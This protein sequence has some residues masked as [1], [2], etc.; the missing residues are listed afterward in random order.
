MN[1]VKEVERIL[2][3]S[4]KEGDLGERTIPGA[5]SKAN[6]EL[7]AAIGG[8]GALPKEARGELRKGISQETAWSLLAFAET[9]ATYALRLSDQALFTNGLLA[10]SMIFGVIDARELMLVMSLYH[11]VHR[12][13]GLS[14]SSIL[15]QNDEFAIFVRDFFARD[16]EGK[17]L[18]SMGYTLARDA[19]NNLTYQRTW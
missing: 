12:R 14:V 1:I 11:D 4:K 3:A 10:L 15:D 19:S 16:E 7:S 8:F 2:E 6:A 5:I 17:S 13:K 18:K 9:M